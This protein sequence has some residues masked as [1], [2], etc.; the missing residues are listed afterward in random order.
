MRSKYDGYYTGDG[1]AFIILHTRYKDESI[2]GIAVGLLAH[3]STH[4]LKPLSKGPH[5]RDS[6]EGCF[7]RAFWESD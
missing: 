6:F 4:L 3:A 5:Y 2:Q 1:D 7:S